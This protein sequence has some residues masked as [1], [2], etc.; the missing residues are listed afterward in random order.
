MEMFAMGYDDSRNDRYYNDN[1]NNYRDSSNRD[2]DRRSSGRDDRSGRSN[3][4]GRDDNRDNSRRQDGRDALRR[5][6]DGMSSMYESISREFRARGHR[7]DDRNDRSYNRRSDDRQISKPSSRYDDRYENADPRQRQDRFYDDRV[8]DENSRQMP[9]NYQGSQQRSSRQP[10]RAIARS[11]LR[12]RSLTMRLLKRKAVIRPSSADLGKK[13]MANIAFILFLVLLVGGFA[14]LGVY[15]NV[16]LNKYYQNILFLSQAQQAATT[17]IYDRN[18][19]LLYQ[20]YNSA[21]T[22]SGI[23]NTITFC[24]LPQTIIRATIDTED[25]TFWTN[26]GVNFTSTLRATYVDLITHGATQGASTI[27]QQVVKNLVLQDSNKSA[28]R[29]LDEAIIALDLAQ[30]YSKQEILTMYLNSVPYGGIVYGIEAA[31]EVYFHL[32]PK[33]IPLDTTTGKPLSGFT[34]SADEQSYYQYA[35][36]NGCIAKGQTSLTESATWQLQP[37][38]A[39]LLAGIPESPAVYMPYSDPACALDRMQTVLNDIY[40]VPG[41]SSYFPAS[42]KIIVPKQF[43]LNPAMDCTMYPF[44]YLADQNQQNLWLQAFDAIHKQSKYDPSTYTRQ[45]HYDNQ[46]GQTGKLAPGFVDYVIQQLSDMLPGGYAQLASSGWRIY[47]TL[48]YGD[49]SIPQSD[50]QKIYVN[51]AT[52]KLAGLPASEIARVGLQQYAEFL[53]YRNI[54]GVTINGFK[55]ATLD[56]WF[57]GSGFGTQVYAYLQQTNALAAPTHASCIV[58]ALAYPDNL[59]GKNVNDAAVV[60]IDP[61]NGNI[62]AMVGSA[63]YYDT[64]LETSGQVNV[65]TSPR[66]LGSS[67]KPVQYST[68]FEMGWNPGVIINDQPTCFPGNPQNITQQPSADVFLC[69]NNYLPHDYTP[70]QWAG[71]QPLTY[72]LGNSLNPPAEL[73]LS[74]VGMQDSYSSPFFTMAQRLGL[75]VGNAPGDLNAAQFGPSTAI[76]AQPVSLLNLTGVYATFADNGYHIP[77]NF[78]ETITTSTGGPILNAATG[79]QLFK[80]GTIPQGYQAISPQASFMMSSVLSNNE[81]RDGDFGPNNPLNYY[82]RSVAAKTGTS[83]NVVDIV[84]E[85]YTPWLAIGV[86]AGN[87]NGA[88]ASPDIIGI[89]GAGY[90]FNYLMDFAIDH[91]NMPGTPPSYEVAQNNPSPGGYFP[92][93][94]DMHLALLD[95]S[96]GMAPVTGKSATTP[97]NPQSYTVPQQMYPEFQPSVFATNDNVAGLKFVKNN[98]TSYFCANWGCIKN[99]YEVSYAYPGLDYTWLINGQDP[100]Q[101]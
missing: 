100:T 47:T 63:S 82:G 73:A 45:I 43:D 98:Y 37:W 44:T 24:Q 75:P 90:I 62:L 79:Q 99:P 53:T 28:T 36:Q 72:M 40:T 84:T 29:K 57:C 55:D 94:A 1:E 16:L 12:R 93:P 81:A 41:D 34:L 70:F 10:L 17:K 19:V 6:R 39:A 23:K 15:S 67:F 14:S 3:R 56:N 95:C 74:F 97:C 85:G 7:N 48:D 61:R 96:T 18:G 50:L 52:G 86:W 22:A 25:K 4:D 31:S 80:A 66:S 20:F 60:A 64:A 30:V 88:P 58:K 68:A 21:S 2:N 101:P 87:A 9:G 83:Q 92:I 89:A 54:F 49:P 27:T 42:G 33:I 13:S 65:A 26:V 11:S 8:Y 38:Q 76:G 71:P 78:I 35:Q 69:G 77:P 91:Y 51:P 46:I 32:A 59:G 5:M